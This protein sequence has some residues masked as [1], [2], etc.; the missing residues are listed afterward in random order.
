MGLRDLCQSIHQAYAE[1]DIARLTTDMYLSNLQ[2]AMTPTDAYACIAQRRTSVSPSTTWKA[3]SPPA[4]SRPTR[5]ASRSFDPGRAL[6]PQDRGLPQVHPRL[7]RQVPRLLTDVH[8]L[9]HEVDEA[10]GRGAYFVD[11]VRD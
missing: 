11:C 3:A 6:Q 4:C 9:V 5:R 7:Q 10:T 1:G 2:P 8:G